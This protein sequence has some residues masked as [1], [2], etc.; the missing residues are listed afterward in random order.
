M[1]KI[2]NPPPSWPQPPAG[3][4]PPPGWE[5][6]PAWGPVPEGHQLWIEED[7]NFPVA[8][9][10][11]PGGIIPGGIIPGGPA[12]MGGASGNAS[13]SYRAPD[14]PAPSY[15]GTAHPASGYPSSSYPGAG[16]PGLPGA[17]APAPKSPGKGLAIS[18][19][20]VA[21]VALV[22]CW[23]PFIN[24]F[25]FFLGLVALGLA[26]AALVI[27]VRRKSTGRGL[28]IAGGSIALVSLI[29]VVITQL[30]VMAALNDVSATLEDSVDGER[31]QTATEQEEVASAVLTPIGQSAPVGSNYEVTVSE[32]VLNANERLAAANMFN[33][34]PVGQYVAVQLDVTYVGTEEGDPWLDLSPT[35]VGSDARQYS[36]TACM[37]TTEMPSFDVPTLENSGS[38]TYQ[39]CFDVPADAIDGGKIFVESDSFGDEGRVYWAIR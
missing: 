34:P 1:G 37:A 9:F 3:W 19:L 35:F 36:A 24:F 28:A 21:I 30:I 22:L 39:E 7:Q 17:P 25:A 12:P 33:E 10:A 5:P 15:P 18:A 20:V 13:G 31:A 11:A 27:T 2:F 14:Y 6:D 29:G 26:I 32:V 4:T 38:G 23:I 8:G 16:Y